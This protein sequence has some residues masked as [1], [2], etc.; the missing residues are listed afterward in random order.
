MRAVATALLVLSLVSSPLFGQAPDRFELG[1]TRDPEAPRQGKFCGNALE[2]RLEFDLVGV[3]FRANSEVTDAGSAE[4]NWGAL[5]ESGRAALAPLAARTPQ[6][7][8]DELAQAIND[9]RAAFARGARAVDADDALDAD[10][11][12]GWSW[13]FLFW[14]ALTEQLA[15]EK[16][17]EGAEQTKRRFET[18]RRLYRELL[19]DDPPD[20]RWRLN[21]AWVWYRLGN[22]AAAEEILAS[23]IASVDGEER[24]RLTRV[25]ALILALGGEWERGAELLERTLKGA[26]ELPGKKLDL[27]RDLRTIFEWSAPHELPRLMWMLIEHNV[28]RAFV[29]DELVD[30]LGKPE[31]DDVDTHE[32]LA[33]VT[34]MVTSEMPGSWGRSRF[35]DLHKIPTLALPVEQMLAVI[36]DPHPEDA[37]YSWWLERVEQIPHA[38]DGTTPRALLSRIVSNELHED[39]LRQMTARMRE[40]WEIA[41][42]PRS[43][44]AMR[45]GGATENFPSAGRILRVARQRQQ[46]L[47]DLGVAA[48]VYAFLE[49]IEAL[50]PTTLACPHLLSVCSLACQMSRID[51][52]DAESHRRTAH[53]FFVELAGRIERDECPAYDDLLPDPENV[54]ASD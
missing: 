44:F 49:R 6:S 48:E 41:S 3:D 21:V 35:A 51:P 29:A 1:C 4:A 28:H 42:I 38:P 53:R 15:G 5:L 50:E 34:A 32:Q 26:G 45:H 20:G 8:P 30:I 10:I 37:S 11:A 27:Y 25:L 24:V 7:D 43:L 17:L 31:I 52:A 9:A 23:G 12:A 46:T 19:R 14:R 18:S 47:A 39:W 40:E 22:T 16:L 36:D 13:T 54:C 2:R 33:Y